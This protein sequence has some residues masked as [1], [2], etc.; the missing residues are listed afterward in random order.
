VSA[1]RDRA[2]IEADDRSNHQ[3]NDFSRA[4]STKISGVNPTGIFTALDQIDKRRE[5]QRAQERK[6]DRGYD[7]PSPF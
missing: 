6:N 3:E 2:T 5:L 7:S 1:S 4:I